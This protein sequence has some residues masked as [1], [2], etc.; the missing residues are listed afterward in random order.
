MKTKTKDL[1]KVKDVFNRIGGNILTDWKML[2]PADEFYEDLA[3]EWLEF[4]I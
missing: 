4:L 3:Y 2:I 1:I